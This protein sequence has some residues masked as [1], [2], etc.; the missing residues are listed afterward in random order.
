[1][2]WPA[3]DLADAYA[4]Q[5]DNITCRVATLSPLRTSPPLSRQ[6]SATATPDFFATPRHPSS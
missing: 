3:L 4:V 5:Q 2:T 1:M 6:L